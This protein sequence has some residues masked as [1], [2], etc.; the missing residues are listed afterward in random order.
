MIRLRLH[1]ARDIPLRVK[2]L[3]NPTVKKFV[4]DAA[5][6][7]ATLQ[8]EKEWFKKYKKEQTKKFF[9]I[10]KG[11]KPIGIVG[12]TKISKMNRNAEAFI[13]IGED[14]ARG[15]G[16]GILAMKQMIRFGFSKLGLHRIF[17]HTYADNKAAIGC[18]KAAGF[19]IEGTL[20]E[21]IKSRKKYR[22]VVVMGILNKKPKK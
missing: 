2:W 8:T 16:Y 20:R 9:T 12:L 14:D 13:M 19:K 21:H 4:D 10:C 18:Y 6:K 22:N 3:N 17:L 11:S 5:A 1:N 7:K 15:K